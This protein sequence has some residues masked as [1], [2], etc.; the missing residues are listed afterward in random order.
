MFTRKC[1]TGASPVGAALC[2]PGVVVMSV[3]AAEPQLT[4]PKLL[5]VLFCTSVVDVV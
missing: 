4:E 1:C 5:N 3:R 2:R